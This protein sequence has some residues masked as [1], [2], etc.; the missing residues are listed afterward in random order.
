[1]LSVLLRFTDSDYTESDPDIPIRGDPVVSLA[2]SLDPPKLP[3]WYL[4]TILT[5]MIWTLPI[6]RIRR[7]YVSILNK[8]YALY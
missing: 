8:C 1:V 6:F 4:Q 3:L 5:Y 7:V 2:L